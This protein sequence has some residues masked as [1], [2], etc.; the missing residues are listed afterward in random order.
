MSLYN[1]IIMGLT[2]DNNLINKVTSNN[3]ELGY[4]FSM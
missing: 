4:C 2:I 1:Y 3:C